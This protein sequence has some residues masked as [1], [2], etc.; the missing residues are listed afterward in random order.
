MKTEVTSLE[1]I[2]RID[3]EINSG[4]SLRSSPQKSARSSLRSS[5]R[6]SVGGIMWPSQGGQEE[7]SE[8]LPAKEDAQRLDEEK[9]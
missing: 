1:T 3:D 2:G 5:P 8:A 6:K 9:Q 4:A 7:K